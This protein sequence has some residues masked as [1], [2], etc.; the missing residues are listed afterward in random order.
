MVVD[1]LSMS[2]VD[3]GVPDFKNRGRGTLRITE[4]PGHPSN[5]MPHPFALLNVDHGPPSIPHTYLRPFPIG[6]TRIIPTS[7]R[8]LVRLSEVMRA[9]S[10]VT[11]A[12]KHCS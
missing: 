9:A 8:A 2:S 7:E 6:R 4:S 11:G 10:G 5:G 3:F 1:Y 12:E